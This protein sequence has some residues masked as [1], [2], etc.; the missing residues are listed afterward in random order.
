[1]Q[2]GIKF[3][4]IWIY[5]NNSYIYHT[6]NTLRK[7]AS[8]TLLLILLFNI[9]GYRAWFYYAE[10]RADAA[11]EFRLD[12]ELYD[13]SELFSLTIPLNDPYL[14]E[15]GFEHT[16]GEIN[17]QGKTYRFVKRKISDGNLVLLCLPDARKMILKKASTD[18]GTATSGMAGNNKNSSRSGAQ[19]HFSGSDYICKF[20]NGQICKFGNEPF[21]FFTRHQFYFSEPHIASPGKPPQ[22]LS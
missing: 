11:M 4:R 2:N 15:Q 12:K 7:F 18:F 8:I 22:P 9:V 3:C 17:F 14:T 21:V 16:V 13:E 20:A 5:S 1:M 10:Q 6:N 19:K